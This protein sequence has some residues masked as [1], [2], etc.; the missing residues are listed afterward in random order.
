MTVL[1]IIGAPRSG[2]TISGMLASQG[3]AEYLGEVDSLWANRPVICNCGAEPDKCDF[4]SGFIEAATT[5][6]DLATYATRLVSFIGK[7]L[8]KEV[9]WCHTS[10]SVAF[11]EVLIPIVDREGHANRV[12]QI[13]RDPRGIAL[14]VHRGWR[15]RK[16]DGSE[17]SFRTLIKTGVSWR[18]INVSIDTRIQSLAPLE[19]FSYEAIVSDPDSRRA[20]LS[21]LM[22]HYDGELRHHHALGGNP[23]RKTDHLV[24]KPDVEWTSRISALRQ[25]VSYVSALPVSKEYSI[26]VVRHPEY[27]EPGERKD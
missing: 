21:F 4:W 17:P 20:F 23:S 11:S 13:V 10:K 15:R 26:P 18:R 14:S 6:P 5:S 1:S 19:A 27:S 8:G 2:T 3:G 22:L 24:F 12:A 16:D 25:A 7:S 9:T